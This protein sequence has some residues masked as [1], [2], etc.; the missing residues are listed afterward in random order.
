[1]IRQ[2]GLLLAVGIAAICLCSIIV[3]LATLGIREY[4]SPTTGRDFREG[5]LGRLV[6]KMGS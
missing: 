1:M 3:P 6:V 5:F 2:F 4:R